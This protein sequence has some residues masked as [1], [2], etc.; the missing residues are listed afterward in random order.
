MGSNIAK[1][2]KTAAGDLL[3]EFDRKATQ[4]AGQY[5]STVAGK[6]GDSANVFTLREESLIVV[7]DLDEVTTETEICEALSGILDRTPIIETTAVKSLRDGF[8]GTRIAVVSLPTA[9]A[10]K[11]IEVGKVRI[12]WVVARIREKD[13]GTKCYRCS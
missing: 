8:R 2:R 1:V 12:G 4:A 13:F 11:A 9:L 7:K 3:L 5:C 10:R 6:L